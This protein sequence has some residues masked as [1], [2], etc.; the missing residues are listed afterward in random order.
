MVLDLMKII[1]NFR[2]NAVLGIVVVILFE[3]NQDGE[4]IKNSA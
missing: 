1:N 2:V 3:L 4:L